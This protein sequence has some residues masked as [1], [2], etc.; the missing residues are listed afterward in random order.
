MGAISLAWGAS[1][2]F[3]KVGLRDFSPPFIVCAR[4]AL[5]AA[6]LLPL[7]HRSGAIAAL[8][9]RWRIIWFLAVVQMAGPFLLITW[10]EEEISSGLTGILVA[11]API[12][13]AL[14]AARGYA[15]EPLG[16][17]GA[18]GVVVGIVGVVLLFASDLSGDAGQLFGGSLV[19][20]AGVGY[21]VGGLV[22]KARMSDVPAV[23]VAGA[24]MVASTALTAV[25][26]AFVFPSS[27]GLDAVSAVVALGALGTGLAFLLFYTLLA[28]IGAPRASIVAYL[29][30]AFSVLYGVVLLDEAITIGA[31]AGLA[32]ILFG[33]Y[34]AAQRRLP[35]TRQPVSRI[36]PSHSTAPEPVRAR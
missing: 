7:A 36:A 18:I 2:L 28:E 24:T 30:S 1:Y 26:A 27:A 22:I 20:L 25:P 35:W 11:S 16:R 34:V 33:S 23:G 5:G 17:W 8:R 15:D 9:G 19:L 10:G 6:I 29:A 12:F 21:A 13:T 32:L 3:I 14:L 31:L 4:V